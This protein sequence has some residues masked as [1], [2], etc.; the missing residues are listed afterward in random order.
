MVAALKDAEMSREKCK[1]LEDIVQG[2][3]K[4]LEE[5]KRLVKELTTSTASP[6]AAGSSS[7]PKVLTS[8]LE[9]ANAENARLKRDLRTLAAAQAAGDAA[10]GGAAGDSPSASAGSS[11]GGKGEGAAAAAL[12]NPF[13]GGE[14]SSPGSAPSAIRADSTG[15]PF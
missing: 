14:S 6:S 11:P 7:D 12:G 2:L 4:D 8:L 13:G 3:S 5:K 15:N 9:K 1:M 10:G